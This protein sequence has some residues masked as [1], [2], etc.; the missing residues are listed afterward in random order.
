MASE[1]N[2]IEISLR[3]PLRKFWSSFFC[4]NS[5]MV[6]FLLAGELYSFHWF[7]IKMFFQLIVFSHLPSKAKYSTKHPFLFHAETGEIIRELSVFPFHTHY[8][9]GF[10]SGHV[11]MW[12]L[13]YKESWAP[14]NWC[15][16]TVGEDPIP[17]SLAESIRNIKARNK[18]SHFTQVSLLGQKTDWS[19]GRVDL[20]DK[21]RLGTMIKS[22]VSFA[23]SRLFL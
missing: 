15:F 13:D 4:V 2:N 5:C 23:I 22:G 12:E 9:Y 1:E 3:P 19:R 11:W 16:W 8:G 20:E 7:Y 6:V 10:S 18:V 21:K 17:Y 14:K